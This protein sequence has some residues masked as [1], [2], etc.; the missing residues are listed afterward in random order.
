MT[1]LRTFINE[2]ALSFEHGNRNTTIVTLIG[3]SQHL[4]LNSEDLEKELEK[5]IENDSFI[6]DEINR[7]WN[8]CLNKDYKKFWNTNKAKELYKF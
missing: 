4:G 1:D 8:Y 3:Y 2:N 6:Q 7:I 5:E